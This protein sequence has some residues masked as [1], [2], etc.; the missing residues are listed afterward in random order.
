MGGAI[1]FD[2]PSIF[3]GTVR[4]ELV[5]RYCLDLNVVS[6]F[7]G[8]SLE[9]VVFAFLIV[10]FAESMSLLGEIFGD[11]TEI[12]SELFKFLCRFHTS[13]EG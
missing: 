12:T 2:M 9:S 1:C 13:G 6:E 3:T 10:S 8:T 7:L 11:N 4:C 5:K